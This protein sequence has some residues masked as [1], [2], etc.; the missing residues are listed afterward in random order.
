MTLFAS[1][2]PDSEKKPIFRSFFRTAK[3]TPPDFKVIAARIVP[4]YDTVQPPM[5]TAQAFVCQP[6]KPLAKRVGD[7]TYW[8]GLRGRVIA[9]TTE[10]KIPAAEIRKHQGPVQCISVFTGGAQSKPEAKISPPQESFTIAASSPF[11]QNNAASSPENAPPWILWDH[12]PA[13][14]EFLIPSNSTSSRSTTLKCFIGSESGHFVSE[15]SGCKASHQNEGKDSSQI[16]V[17]ISLEPSDLEDLWQVGARVNAADRYAPR[18]LKIRIT[19]KNPLQGPVAES[20]L[21]LLRT[22]FAPKIEA[23]SPARSETASGELLCSATIVDPERDHTVATLLHI[24]RPDSIKTKESAYRIHSQGNARRPTAATWER[25][26]SG[27]PTL[28]ELELSAPA[29]ENQTCSFLAS[30]G[31]LITSLKTGPRRLSPE[32]QP[33]QAQP[34]APALHVAA[35]RARAER[36]YEHN[37]DL[38]E[39]YGP[40]NPRPPALGQWITLPARQGVSPRTGPLRPGSKLL[41]CLGPDGESCGNTSIRASGNLVFDPSAAKSEGRYI[42]GSQR[43]DERPLIDVI[44]IISGHK[45]SKISPIEGNLWANAI[46]DATQATLQSHPM[47]QTSTIQNT[48]SQARFFLD[49]SLPSSQKDA[50]KGLGRSLEQRISGKA[51]VDVTETPQI[52][53]GLSLAIFQPDPESIKAAPVVL[54][55]RSEGGKAKQK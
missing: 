39:G 6:E 50:C 53:P 15:L 55:S 26:P 1:E 30:D 13:V 32:R 43:H 36:S 11:N 28:T 25:L 19:P 8:I 37:A 2:A 29:Q 35:T 33:P 21:L 49:C 34:G 23:Q 18:R 47:K 38:D 41:F 5:M 51:H 44:E 52:L 42:I 4:H 40:W 46:R 20:P 31:I 14:K 54:W 12:S 9:R 7:V 17:Q 48:A 27:K 24:D 16:R 3:S 22:N 10:P 45:A